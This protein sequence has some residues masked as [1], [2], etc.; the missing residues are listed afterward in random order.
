MVSLTMLTHNRR[1]DVRVSLEEIRKITYPNWEMIVVDNNSTDGVVDM[2][3]KEYP[4]IKLIVLGEN[5]PFYARGLCFENARGKYVVVLDDDSHPEPDAITKTVER[6][7]NDPCLGIIAC[8][9]VCGDHVTTWPWP[10]SPANT[11]GLFIACGAGFRKEVFEQIGAYWADEIMETYADE[12]DFTYRAYAAGYTLGHFKDIIVHH[13]PRSSPERVRRFF[14]RNERNRSYLIG[15][16]IPRRYWPQM[17]FRPLLYQLLKA[18]YLSGIKG[19]LWAAFGN[20]KGL[21]YLIEGYRRRIIVPPVVIF[22]ILTSNT[23]FPSIWRL[24]TKREV[25]RKCFAGLKHPV[26]GHSFCPRNLP[27]EEKID[28]ELFRT[29]TYP[30]IVKLRVNEIRF[31]LLKLRKNVEEKKRMANFILSEFDDLGQDVPSD[32]VN[33]HIIQQRLTR[34]KGSIKDFL[35]T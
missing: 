22:F 21:E 35:I 2:I 12:F 23:R 32:L 13:R 8:N 17:Y 5:R 28:R 33:P 24:F 31:E 9:V 14:Y 34:L 4:W 7:E 25:R 16:Y 15:K 1:D 30:F 6:F 26:F 11:G 27:T 18:Y 29:P 19:L 3:K 10:E 20:M